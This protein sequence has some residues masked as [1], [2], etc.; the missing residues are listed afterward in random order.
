[1]KIRVMTLKEQRLL[2]NLSIETIEEL[3]DIFIFT[4]DNSGGKKDCFSIRE[5]CVCY[6]KSI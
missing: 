6:G 1:M 5:R 2:G 4:K 3:S